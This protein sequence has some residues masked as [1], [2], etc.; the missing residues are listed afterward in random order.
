MKKLPL[1]MFAILIL[2]CGT[3]TTVVEKRPSVVI[4]DEPSHHPLIAHGTVKHGQVNVDPERSLLHF[5]FTEPF[6]R[7]QILLREKDGRNPR[8]GRSRCYRH[9]HHLHTGNA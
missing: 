9:K 4:I 8:L 1:L 3:E 6:L 2:S 7:Y 5:E